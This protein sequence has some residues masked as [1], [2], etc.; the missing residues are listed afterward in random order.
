MKLLQDNSTSYEESGSHLNNN[1]SVTNIAQ[2]VPSHL[3][4]I[5]RQCNELFLG[6]HSSGFALEET[7]ELEEEG[8]LSDKLTHIRET[9]SEVFEDVSSLGAEQQLILMQEIYSKAQIRANSLAIGKDISLSLPT[10][11]DT[12]PLYP[13][14]KKADPYEWLQEHWGKWL[15]YFN[16]SNA[17]QLYRNQ[18]RKLD[19]ALLKALTNYKDEIEKKHNIDLSIVLPSKEDQTADEVAE[20]TPQDRKKV[21]RLFAAMKKYN[22]P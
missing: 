16:K 22:H 4:E 6:C 3:G 11:D 12:Y 10:E 18:L 13:G 5:D 20:M 9:I 15:R 7:D 21:Y 1:S 19:P 17:N 14:K 2:Y 8:E